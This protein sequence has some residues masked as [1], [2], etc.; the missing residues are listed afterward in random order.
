M[1]AGWINGTLEIKL[2]YVE[3]DVRWLLQPTC[4]PRPTVTTH[5]LRQCDRSAVR[6]QS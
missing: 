5:A 3:L 4:V 2:L 6:W 1:P